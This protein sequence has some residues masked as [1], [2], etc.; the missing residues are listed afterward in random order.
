MAD[1]VY[2]DEQDTQANQVLRSAVASG[3]FAQNEVAMVIPAPTIRESIELILEHSCKVLI[4]DY[5]L[6]EY[7]PDVQF[8]GTEL[9]RAF[10][11]RFARFPCF[12]TTSFA[13]EAI[14]EPIDTNVIF[15]KSDFLDNIL[16]EEEVIRSEIPFFLRVKK[17]IAAYESFVDSTISEWKELSAKGNR[18]ELTA[19]EVERL[20]QLDDVIEAL[21]GKDVAIQTHI[22]KH[23]LVPFHRLIGKAEALIKK[24]ESEIDGT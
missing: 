5:R 2:V 10:Q 23:A 19:A 18:E 24:I 7:K 15:P 12:V 14:N 1:L 16:P 8:T 11:Q 22:K 3:Q 13:A 4:V 17:K 20:I 6:S 9:V 21:H